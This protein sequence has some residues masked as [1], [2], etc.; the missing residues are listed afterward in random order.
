LGIVS[1]AI[2]GTP[3]ASRQVR[4]LLALGP[5]VG[6]MAQH[7]S[8]LLR[9]LDS[10]RF[11]VSLAGPPDDPAA[12]AARDRSCPVHPIRFGP[13]PKGMATA[14][15][16]LAALIR[17]ERHDIV[18]AHGYSAAGAAAL[19]RRLTPRARLVCT[20]H[21]FLTA[22]SARAITGW[23]ARWLLHLIARRADRI[24]TVSDSLHEQFAGIADA[25]H[26]KLVTI[27]NGIDLRGFGE[28]DPA[29]ARHELRL[30]EAGPVVGMVGRLAAQK[31]PLD[32]VRA[33]AVAHA[34]FPDAYFVLI[35]DGPLR[36]EVEKLAGDLGIS[37]SLMLAG[38]RPDAPMLT[39]VFDVAVIASVSEGSSLTA[40]EAMA[41]G[42]PVAGTAVGGVREVVVDGETGI[43]V[44]PGEAQALGEA[45]AS[46]LADPERARA[47]G[48]A[49]RRRVEREFSLARMIERTEE[50]YLAVAHADDG[51]EGRRCA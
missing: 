22:T 43:L 8:G 23:R 21:N 3:V 12:A 29:S 49:G 31:G 6:G 46:L 33:A 48:E 9:G 5:A 30:P 38:H 42:K 7:V 11:D 44:P 39:E 13:S 19:A 10:N 20:L 45:V 34:R 27:A 40:M 1:R 51:S 15:V 36:G 35:G 24:I 32:F 47:L 50:V 2:A 28:S 26:G 14:S 37:N 41:W 17:R 16:R 18:H 25:A 4:V